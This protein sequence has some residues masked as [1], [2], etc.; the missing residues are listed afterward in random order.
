MEVK[1]FLSRAAIFAASLA[2]VSPASAMQLSVPPSYSTVFE[3]YSGLVLGEKIDD[4]PAASSTLMPPAFLPKDKALLERGAQQMQNNLNQLDRAMGQATKMGIPLKPGMNDQFQ[5]MQQMLEKLKRVQSP[6]DTKQ[7][8]LGDVNANLQALGAAGAEMQ[9]KMESQRT[10]KQSAQGMTQAVT[11]FE[12]QIAKLTKQGLTVPSDISE[13]L[14]KAKNS[15][16]TLQSTTDAD[17][18]EQASNDAQSAF[19]DLNDSRQELELL[20]RWKQTLTQVDRQLAQLK[21]QR[22]KDATTAK[23]LAAQN[24]D[25]SGEVSS[26]EELFTKLQAARDAA[27]AS[28]AAGS[29]QDAFDNLQIDFFDAQSDVQQHRQIID[30][31]AQLT[32]FASQNKSSLSAM[33]R[34]VTK[35]KAKKLDT[36]TLED[37]LSQFTAKG[38]EILAEIKNPERD[39]DTLMSELQDLEDLRAQFA[40]EQ[41]LLLGSGVLLPWQG[42]TAQFKPLTV[43]TA[44]KDA[45]SDKPAAIASPELPAQE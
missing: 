44:I 39:P 30:T 8:N 37:I 31:M 7:I 1:N 20:A 26:L 45:A 24:I 19:E 5:Q 17:A 27:V 2:L 22:V 33:K 43:P 36:A 11:Q 42:G 4:Q 32:R 3:Q 9:A 13:A 34:V 15:L 41:E 29:V 18:L 10:V 35:A 6:L 23:R 40:D 21:K 25:I 38:N 14:A 16:A 12:K 28:V